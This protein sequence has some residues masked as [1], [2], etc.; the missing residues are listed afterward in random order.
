MTPKHDDNP[1]ALS[2]AL[3]NDEIVDAKPLAVDMGA[4]RAS[5]SKES[6][7][8]SHA[9]DNIIKFLLLFY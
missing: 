6:V 4:T 5:G 7:A 8:R 2:T 1:M 3:Q 9:Y